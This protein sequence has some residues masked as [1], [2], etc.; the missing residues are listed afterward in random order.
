MRK[1]KT[2][3]VVL[4]LALAPLAYAQDGSAVSTVRA[5][6]AAVLSEEADGL[7]IDWTGKGTVAGE[8]LDATFTNNGKGALTV[9][10]VPGI[11]LT[12]K[13]QKAQPI[14]LEDTLK[15]TLQPGESTSMPLRG[16]CL[17]FEL[18]PPAMGAGVDY[19]V[20]QDVSR[21]ETAIRNLWAGLRLDRDGGFKPVLKPLMH[22]TIV[23]QRS[24][25]A[26]LGGNNPTTV[27]KLDEDLR[28]DT[29]QAGLE[30]SNQ[31]VRFLTNR[32]WDDVEKTQAAA[33]KE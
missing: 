9:D 25:W 7:D 5:A 2:A 21:Y 20:A 19:E 23:I 28:D 22:R 24:I 16:Y 17:D 15:F 29:A 30:Y 33:P 32:I 3:L 11:V 18:D 4:W 31:K 6:S 10:I 26:S 12:D 14:M 1:F 8:M 27:E 13:E